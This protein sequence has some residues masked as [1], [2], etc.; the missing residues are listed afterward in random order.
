MKK[1]FNFKKLLLSLFVG[2]S[3]LLSLPLPALA[4]QASPGPWYSQS[5]P[6]WYS[7]VYDTTN[8]NEIFG[9]RYTS[10]Q[11]QWV[12]WGVSSFFIDVISGYNPAVR[13]CISAVFTGNAT[14]CIQPIIDSQKSINS[15]FKIGDSGK[16]QSVIGMIFE[17]RSLSGITY[18]KDLGRKFSI[19][20]EAKA[21]STGFG[22]SGALGVVPDIQKVWGI[23]RNLSYV[24]F[25]FIIMVFAFMIMFRVKISPQVVVSVQSALPKIAIALVLVTFSYAIAGFLIDLMYVVIGIL[26]LIFSQ[27]T[28]FGVSFAGVAGIGVTNPVA[29]Y[30]TL[31]T[32]GPTWGVAK[33]GVFGLMVMYFVNYFLAW[34]FI[35][36]G[37]IGSG[38][39]GAGGFVGGSV[40]AV[41]TLIIG[42]VGLIIVFILSIINF[43]K[44]IIL[45]VKSFASIIL[46]TIFAPLQL[47]LGIV[48]P[49]LGFGSWVR[50]F[51][52]KLAVFPAVGALLIIA[53]WFLQIAWDTVPN[54]PTFLGGGATNFPQGWPP[55]LGGSPQLVALAFLLASIAVFIMIPKA[56]DAVDAFISGKQFA[57]GTAIGQGVSIVTAPILGLGQGVY[58]AGQKALGE[59][60]VTTVTGK[61]A[62][63][64]GL[65]GI[66]GGKNNTPRVDKNANG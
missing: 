13:G 15:Q 24:I 17:D 18:V 43:F 11:V 28:V 32:Q 20:P 41:F 55:L 61:I 4:Q 31:L 27:F 21:Q 44:I 22:F 53:L 42:F 56:G 26:S 50:S 7:K 60:A 1:I 6:Q 5:F 66:F 57:F 46:L 59:T 39:L 29:G 19:I 23:V 25:V 62:E 8:P 65:S 2:I 58:G 37:G 47:T 52:A 30:F 48:V 9:E 3:L 34:V 64:G 33:T 45:L 38:L 16:N 51:V 49:G 40:V 54:S 35:V 12:F 14:A 10:A 63:R 36:I